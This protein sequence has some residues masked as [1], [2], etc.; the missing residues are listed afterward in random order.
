MSDVCFMENLS[1]LQPA[2]LTSLRLGKQ[3]QRFIILFVSYCH[4]VKPKQIKEVAIFSD[5]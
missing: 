2:A 4:M 5:T 1:S 3:A